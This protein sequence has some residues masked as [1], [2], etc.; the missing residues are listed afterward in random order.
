MSTKWATSLFLTM[1]FASWVCSAQ[2]K[3]PSKLILRADETESG[4]YGGQKSSSCLRIYSDGRVAYSRRWNSAVTVVD[5]TGR[6]SRPEHTVSVEYHL[7]DFE[8]EELSELFESKVLKRLP[9]KFAPPH[10]PVDYIKRQPRFKSHSRMVS[11]NRFLPANSMLQVW[12][13][14]LVTLR[15]SLFLWR[16]SMKLRRKRPTKASQP[17]LHSTVN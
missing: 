16:K 5:E 15:P 13:K 12:K 10:R 17:K 9:E 14:R 8:V 2:E 1:L 3:A 11:R 7:E 6:K 4:P